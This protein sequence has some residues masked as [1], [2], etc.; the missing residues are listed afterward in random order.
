MTRTC[1]N[2][3]AFNGLAYQRQVTDQ[4]K[5]LM[6]GRLIGVSQLGVVKNTFMMLSD[7][8]VY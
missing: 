1:C 8:P 6:P 7:S 3:L 2:N 5:Q 4:V